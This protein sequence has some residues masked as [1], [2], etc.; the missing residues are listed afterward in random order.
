MRIEL[1]ERVEQVLETALEPV[2]QPA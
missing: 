1:V 2:P